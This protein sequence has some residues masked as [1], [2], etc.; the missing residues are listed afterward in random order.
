[1]ASAPQ[2]SRK[3]WDEKFKNETAERILSAD[4]PQQAYDTARKELRIQPYQLLAWVGAYAIAHGS[5][6]VRQAVA[7][8]PP[9]SLN[10]DEKS[11]YQI[12]LREH[13]KKVEQG[14]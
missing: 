1:M 2:P 9:E 10:A 8:Q 13:F 7:L 4:N 11:I 5:R 14:L 12:L 3:S 6:I